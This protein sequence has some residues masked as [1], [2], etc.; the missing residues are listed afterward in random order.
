MSNRPVLLWVLASDAFGGGERL[1]QRCLQGL[2]EHFALHLLTQRALTADFAHIPDL[3]IHCFEDHGLTAPHDYRHGNVLHYARA[4][5]DQARACGAQV[6]HAAMHNASW[7]LAAAR[8][9]HPLR[10]R[11]LTLIGSLHGSL[12]GY[13]HT[14]RQ[15]PPT[16]RVRLAVWLAGR[17]LDGV[18][19][20]S[21]GVARELF[22]TFK[23][24]PACLH[25]I[26]NGV[27]RATLRQQVREAVT[28]PVVHQKEGYAVRWMVGAGRLSAQKDFETLLQ[29]FAP[30]ARVHPHWHVLIL[31]SGEREETLRQLVDALALGG[32]VHLVGFQSN[33]YPWIGSADLFVLS[34]RYKG[35]GLVLTEAMSLGVPVIASDC[36]WGPGE[37]IRHGEDGLLFPVGDEA[38]LSACMASLMTDGAGRRALARAGVARAADFSEQAM[39]SGYARVLG[40][41][42]AF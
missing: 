37:I 10:A 35:F 39:I 22:Q 31:G 2:N 19:T 15:R 6:V 4:I 34:S 5:L 23:V 17:L 18:I 7:F 13:Y 32:R 27:D 8:L 24:S 11:G 26:Y 30:L 33:P 12:V 40:R 20:P 1:S 16:L 21:E 14:E 38:A 36:P 3:R 42:G 29:A 9:R 41:D 28:L 25:T